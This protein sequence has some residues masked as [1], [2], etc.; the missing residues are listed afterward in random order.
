[1]LGELSPDDIFVDV[2]A[3][4]GIYSLYA[5]QRLKGHGYVFAIEPSP[6]AV[7]V[8]RQNVTLNSF[9]STISVAHAAASR[10]KGQLYLAGDP[11]KWNSLQLHATPPGTLIEVTTVDSILAAQAGSANFHFLKIDAEGVETD[12]LAGA[13]ESIQNTWPT[14]IFENTI[15]RSNELPAVWLSQR[16][17][18]IHAINPRGRLIEVL[19]ANYERHT[20]LVATHPRSR[21]S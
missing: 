21:K 3:N 16:G 1:L 10:D 5:A 11:T 6:D 15:N 8:L 7:N 17:Y 12:V 18:T 20:N 9:A 4:I 14:I 19:P 13:Q 2:G